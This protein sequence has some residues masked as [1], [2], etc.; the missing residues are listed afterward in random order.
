MVLI[1]ESLDTGKPFPPLSNS[2]PHS[3]A[4]T[5]IVFLRCLPFPIVPKE[6]YHWCIDSQTKT[7]ALQVVSKFPPVHFYTF[8]YLISFLREIVLFQKENQ[9]LILQ[10]IALLFSTVLLH[11]SIDDRLD[12]ER[13]KKQKFIVLLLSE[14]SK[15]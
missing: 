10:Q 7:R 6:L 2:G 1:R 11:Q 13:R 3:V 12:I 8:T 14:E 9:Q 4:E 15:Q 5:L